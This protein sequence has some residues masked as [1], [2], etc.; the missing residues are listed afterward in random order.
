MGYLFLVWVMVARGEEPGEAPIEPG[1]RGAVTGLED[2]PIGRAIR[3]KLEALSPEALPDWDAA[4]VAREAGDEATAR[5][6]YSAV[7]D[8]APTFD[9]GW[10]RR[11]SVQT[12]RDAALA[13]SAKALE[14]EQS[15]LNEITYASTLTEGRQQFDQ[16]AFDEI[17]GHIDRAVAVAPDDPA[18]LVMCV[19]LRAAFALPTALDCFQRLV[20][21]DPDALTTAMAGAVAYGVA[22]DYDAAQGWLDEARAKGLPAEAAGPLAALVAEPPVHR[23]QRLAL[24]AFLAWLAAGPILFVAGWLLSRASLDAA[25][26]MLVDPGSRDLNVGLRALYSAV[27]GLVCVYYFVSLPVLGA[28]VLAIAAAFFAIALVLRVFWYGPLIVAFSTVFAMIRSVFVGN[29][30]GETQNELALAEQPGLKRI[31]DGVAERVGTRPIDKVY[32]Q[33]GCECAVYEEASLVGQL[34]GRSRRCF[35]VGVDLL[36]SIPRGY[37]RSILAHEYG[38]F[39]HGDTAGGRFAL[40][41]RR[42]FWKLVQEMV[43]SG[44][45]GNVNPAWWYVNGFNR[46]FLRVSH[47]ASRLRELHADRVSARAYGSETFV[48]AMRFYLEREVRFEAEVNARINAALRERQ[49]MPNLYAFAVAPPL[50]DAAVSDKVEEN[51]ARPASAYDSHP[52]PADRFVWVRAVPD[53]GADPDPE[54]ERL[55]WDDIVDGEAIE[56]RMTEQ[57]RAAVER[58]HNVT[59][60]A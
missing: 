2:D 9:G 42:S 49:P 22:G 16:P 46:L 37:L 6:R 8:A 54:A 29:R 3:A 5:A 7:I 24:T 52:P 20:A 58:N 28:L 55:V 25:N 26:R 13:D 10:R 41:V 57:V 27:I 21:V 15:G 11:S 45:A 1:G 17:Q 44:V 50:T 59:F 40:T 34:L 33:P 12:D 48:K 47:G 39:S 4:N 23:A 32:L 38:H 36:R 31:L 56:R 60:A 18:V 35:V 53:G 14:I 30:Q 51:V 43:G 19:Q